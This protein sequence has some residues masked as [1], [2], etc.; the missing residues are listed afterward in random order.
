MAA[1]RT[2]YETL[3]V[4]PDAE[5]VVIEAA[6]RALMK[7]YHPDQGSGVVASNAPTAASIN[8]AYAVLREAGRRAEYDRQEWARQQKIKLESYAPPPP[9]R[10]T[11]FFGWGGWLVALVLA[12]M[13]GILASK[14]RFDA[15]TP[16]EKARAAA[17]GEPDRRSQ[18]FLPG[19]QPSEEELAEIRADAF[20]R[21]PPAPAAARSEP[22][23]TL[24]VIEP[25]TGAIAVPPA[26]EAP[27]PRQAAPR[28][29]VRKPVRRAPARPATKRERDFLEREGY[30][31]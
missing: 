21:P 30:I 7:K 26:L 29:A 10:R 18:P 5:G 4:S 14:G 19:E 20:A 17:L 1:L 3:N 28:R 16:A 25:A 31:Y 24:P 27:S 15:L 23:A 13:F 2:H 6:Y 12:G 22:V 9:P 8:E 11:N